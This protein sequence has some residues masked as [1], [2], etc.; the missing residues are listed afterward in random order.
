MVGLMV[1]QVMRYDTPAWS[2]P[3]S[4]STRDTVGTA[5]RLME[6]AD[7]QQVPVLDEEGHLVGMVTRRDIRAALPRSDADIHREVID[8][9]VPAVLGRHADGVKVDVHNRTVTLYGGVDERSACERLARSVERVAGV[10]S[11]VNVLSYR[12]DGIAPGRYPLP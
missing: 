5:A 2:G 1:S 8:D 11:V 4:V 10:E 6:V 7:I 12:H 9:V 3:I